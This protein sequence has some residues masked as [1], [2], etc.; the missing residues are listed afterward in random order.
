MAH[1]KGDPYITQA[2][3]GSIC[4]ECNEE[5]NKGDKIIIWPRASSGRKARHFACSEADYNHSQAAF[6]DEAIMTGK[7]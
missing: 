3:F 4:P 1:K 2:R 6:W 5:I 7:H